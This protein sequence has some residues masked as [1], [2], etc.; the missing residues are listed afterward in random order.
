MD[1]QEAQTIAELLVHGFISR[2][3]VPILMHT[4]KGQ[5]LS[6]HC[7]LRYANC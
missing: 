3:R 4:D 6:L 2:F 5:N 7:S 1:N